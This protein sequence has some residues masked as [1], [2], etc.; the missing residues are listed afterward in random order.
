[1]GVFSTNVAAQ[2]LKVAQNNISKK[3]MNVSMYGWT[4]KLCEKQKGEREIR[5]F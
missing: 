2:Q 1:M 4:C 5:V 3:I